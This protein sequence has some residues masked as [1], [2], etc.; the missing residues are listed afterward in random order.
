[1]EEVKNSIKKE[2]DSET[3]YN[4]KY[5]KIEIKSY[6][7]KTSTKVKSCSGKINTNFYKNK[8]LKGGSQIICLSVIFIDSV[9]WTGKNY[10]P[11]VFLE[12]CNYVVKE[13]NMPQ[14]ITDNT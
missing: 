8:I 12:K 6:N 1:M 10:Y 7:W 3:V 5:L 2:F 13:K 9:F 14:Y 4:E 11:Q